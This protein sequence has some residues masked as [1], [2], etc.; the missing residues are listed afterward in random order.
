[1]KL[2][3]LILLKRLWHYMFAKSLK[4]SFDETGK[5]INDNALRQYLKDRLSYGILSTSINMAMQ[6]RIKKKYNLSDKDYICLVEFLSNGNLI[7]SMLLKK[8]DNE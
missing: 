4:I 3:L 5:P 6:S 8:R 2:F 7:R 1:M